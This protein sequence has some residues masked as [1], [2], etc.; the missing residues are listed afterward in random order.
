MKSIKTLGITIK[1]IDL[2]E[3]DRL[4]TIFTYELG[5][6]RAVV[7]G[8]KKLLSKLAGH[9]EPLSETSFQLHEGKSFYTVTGAELQSSFTTIRDDLSKTGLALSFLESI[10]S[11]TAEDEPHMVVYNQLVESLN[12]L[13]ES[14]QSLTDRLLKVHFTLKLLSELGYLPEL[15]C[16]V[17][18]H[19]PLV[20]S[21]N[22]FSSH[23]GGVVGA[24]CQHQDFEAIKL[25]DTAIKGMRLFLD[26]PVTVSERL[27]VE[28]GVLR[29]L[30][31][32]I[33][34]YLH[35]HVG[36]ELHSANFTKSTFLSH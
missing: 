8:A 32:T 1:R 24:E 35:Y 28:K 9:V 18:C 17:S 23:L 33:E 14:D 19:Q 31:D 10:D 11:L 29:E 6:V 5:K 36:R 16:C 13:E 22:R 26:Q 4:L 34:N 7:R 12:V 25:S 27:K 30:E 2:G 21:D 15:T 20:P 3:A